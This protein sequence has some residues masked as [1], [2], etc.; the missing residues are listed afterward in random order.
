V[1]RT[2]KDIP[3]HVLKDKATRSGFTDHN[4]EIRLNWSRRV[5][6]SKTFVSFIIAVEDK[7]EALIHDWVEWGKTIPIDLVDGIHTDGI[8]V[9]VERNVPNDSKFD[10]PDS[11]NKIITQES[12]YTRSWVGYDTGR[13]SLMY[14]VKPII[15]IINEHHLPKASSLD[16]NRNLS[17]CKKVAI[18][19]VIINVITN[20]ADNT[21]PDVNSYLASTHDKHYRHMI[22][23][24]YRD[25][26][27]YYPSRS[28]IKNRLRKTVKDANNGLIDEDFEDIIIDDDRPKIVWF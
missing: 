10:T 22:K 20:H 27:K 6:G 12:I 7:N 28:S 16:I 14:A 11:D 5:F 2:I 26:E 17:N 4:G 13:P 8:D 24:H 18:I 1:S 21:M 19:T 25:V 9:T 15:N 3:N 23:R